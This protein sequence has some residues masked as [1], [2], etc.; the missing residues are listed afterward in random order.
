[1]TREVC[2]ELDFAAYI[3]CTAKLTSQTRRFYTLSWALIVIA[4]TEDI[5][6]LKRMQIQIVS[7]VMSLPSPRTHLSG[8]HLQRLWPP[9]HPGLARYVAPLPS[10]APR[11]LPVREERLAKFS[12]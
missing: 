5:A 9:G 1:M 10:E 6:L 4:G 11:P 7:V 12:S 3:P 8:K 2:K